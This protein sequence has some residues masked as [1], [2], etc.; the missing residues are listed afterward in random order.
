[1]SQRI[2]PLLLLLIL[3]LAPKV[4]LSETTHSLLKVSPHVSQDPTPAPWEDMQLSSP[5]ITSVSEFMA[6][7]LVRP[8]AD[9]MDNFGSLH[10]F[11]LMSIAGRWIIPDH[12]LNSEPS[13]QRFDAHLQHFCSMP[14]RTPPH[15]PAFPRFFNVLQIAENPHIPT[16]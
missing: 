4:I 13:G 12:Q 6:P 10:K 3:R 9:P 2:G 16:P 5:D 1:V 14:F 7:T 11:E 8:A 15:A